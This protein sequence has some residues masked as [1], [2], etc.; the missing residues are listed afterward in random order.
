VL[1]RLQVLI[2]TLVLGVISIFS[3]YRSLLPAFEDTLL[4]MT[5]ISS[6]LYVGLKWPE[7]PT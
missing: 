3:I 7:K 6:G 4:A 2:W 1:Q 5:G